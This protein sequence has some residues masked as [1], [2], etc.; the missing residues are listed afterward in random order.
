MADERICVGAIAGAFGVRGEVRVKSFCTEPEA[1]ASYAPLYTEDGKRSFSLKITRAIPGG[2]AAQI[3]GITT[4]EAADALRGTSLFADRDRLPSLPDDEFYHADLIGLAVF[5]TGGQPV[6][7]VR[8]IYN[9]G[10]GD[11]LEIHAPGRRTTLLLP[12]TKAV[13]PTVD[14]TAGRIIADL[15]EESEA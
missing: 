8:A 15:P 14:L 7:T 9:H 13:V 2:L 11:I 6:G 3:S 4:K 5:D 1:I 10:A 12:F